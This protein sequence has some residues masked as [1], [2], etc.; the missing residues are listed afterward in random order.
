MSL[1]PWCWLLYNARDMSLWPWCWL[2]YDVRDMSL[3]PWCW[4][5]YDV[6]DMSLWPC[7][8]LLYNVLYDVTLAV[9]LQLCTTEDI[10]ER[11][12]I[13]ARLRQLKEAREGR[14]CTH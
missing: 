8:W 5:L 11:L 2:L 3:W 1:W 6:R 7:C 14:P 12:K 4:L 9:V 13:R 10:K